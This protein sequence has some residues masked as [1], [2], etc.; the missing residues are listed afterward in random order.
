MLTFCIFALLYFLPAI[1]AHNKR[2]F[3]AILLVD[4]LLGWTVIGW[5][6]ALIWACA[7]EHA[8]P[9]VVVIPAG[10][11]AGYAD[12]H[13]CGFCGAP[14]SQGCPHCRRA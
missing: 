9:R 7:D 1:L 13:F 11:A 6:A 5:I 2:N 10:A 3:T 12:G 4:A 14:I 8:A